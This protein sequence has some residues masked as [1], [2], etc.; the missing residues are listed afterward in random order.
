MIRANLLEPI[1][2]CHPAQGHDPASLLRDHALPQAPIDPYQLIPLAKYV[3]LF[4]Q[5]AH[6]VRDP[7]LGL[8][9]GQAFRPELWGRWDLSSR[10]PPI[11]AR[12]Y[13]SLSA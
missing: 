11:S 4:E 8:R 3:A 10:H 9:L 7:F 13:S 1:L 2:E 5:A 6:L 12:H